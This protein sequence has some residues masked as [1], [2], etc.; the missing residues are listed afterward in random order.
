[1]NRALREAEKT[2]DQA[3]KRF[4][5]LS[6]RTIKALTRERDRLW[7][8]V[9]A[10]NARSKRLALQIRAKTERLSKTTATKTKS[11][12]QKQLTDLK[13]MRAEAREEAKNL[14]AELAA[15]RADLGSARHHL[16]RAAHIDK[17]MSAFEKQREKA[18]NRVAKKRK[19]KKVKKSNAIQPGPLSVP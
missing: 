15:A 18:S 4:L 14:R 13:K 9:K 19:K 5:T 2:F 7:R 10:T 11:T 12:L 6:E 17:A 3:R 1:M 16:S 8:K